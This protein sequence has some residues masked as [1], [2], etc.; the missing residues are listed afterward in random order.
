[1]DHGYE[2]AERSLG[3]S[4]LERRERFHLAYRLASR[5]YQVLVANRST[6]PV[7]HASLA[8][9]CALGDIMGA[10][11]LRRTGRFALG[12]R[13][14]VD[15]TDTALWSQGSSGLELATMPGV[16]LAIEAGLRI[17]A[18]GLIVPLVNATV[19]GAIRHRNGRPASNTSFRYQM[20]AV[21]LGA[22]I[23]SYERNRRAVALAL[24]EQS[25]EAQAGAANLA[26]QNDVATGAD[27]VVDLLSRT[28]PLLSS[29]AGST[30]VGR[31][32]AERTPGVT[33]TMKLCKASAKAFP[34]PGHA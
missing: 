13:L 29:T 3:P 5:S 26:G 24:H 10:L 16:P 25:L 14:V 4:L 32:L 21:A 6:G 7:R 23:A 15:A 28:A 1:M 8:I 33:P 22:G 27:T 20:M 31:M 11:V 30:M 12:P 17:G 9:A 19:T 2:D 34:W 18:A